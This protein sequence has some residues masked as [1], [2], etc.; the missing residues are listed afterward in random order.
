MSFKI[1]IVSD[2]H[3]PD[4]VRRLPDRL[5]DDF[6]SADKIIHAGDLTSSKVMEKLADVAP[7]SCVHGNCDGISLRRK[8]PESFTRSW[9]GIKISACHGYYSS[10]NILRNLAYQFDESR[11]IIFGH[12]H[13]AFKSREDDRLFIN[14]GSPTVP[15]GQSSGTYAILHI[16]EKVE[17]DNIRVE[18]K[19]VGSSP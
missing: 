4:R 1:G 9:A 2:T 8:L 18:F 3:I 17:E 12:T 5:L 16:E 13:R 10:R 19:K 15:R 11:V 6:S 14:P 7:V